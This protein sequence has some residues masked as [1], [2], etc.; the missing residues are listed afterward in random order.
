MNLPMLFGVAS[1]AIGLAL[2]VQ[3]WPLARAPGWGDLR[4]FSLVALTAAL[5]TVGALG[6]SAPIADDLVPWA[7]R[8]QLLFLGLH[9]AAWWAY[10]SAYLARPLGPRD[11]AVIWGSALL[12]IASLVPGVAYSSAVRLH[13][14][15]WL[16]VTYRSAETTAPSAVVFAAIVAVP[17]ALAI[18]FARVSRR[19]DPHALKLSAALLAGTALGVHD[20]VVVS[21]GFHLPYLM[22]FGHI[23]P[24]LVAA[25]ANLKRHVDEAGALHRLKLGLEQAVEE[26]TREIERAHAALVEAEKAAAV[27]RFSAQLAHDMNS[28]A[29]VVSTNLRYVLDEL[30]SGEPLGEDGVAALR[31]SHESM[32]RVVAIAR[33]L[34]DA[35]RS[36]PARE[37][38]RGGSGKDA[39][40][41]AEPPAAR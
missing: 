23:I 31:E 18:R 2:A 39:E 30:E 35:S 21:L 14:V 6:S 8:I 36:R 1:A 37:G 11:R 17:V 4:S 38:G 3:S 19:G 33:Q 5:G 12:G 29:A 32:Q 24:I 10:G 40:K 41:D 16:G 26:R 20:S 7:G 25:G 34:V 27:G 15:P 9:V 22:E 13:A 28:P